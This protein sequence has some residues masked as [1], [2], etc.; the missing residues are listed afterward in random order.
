[1]TCQKNCFTL[2]SKVLYQMTHLGNT[3][4][5]QSIKWLPEHFQQSD[6]TR[7]EMQSGGKVITLIQTL[8]DFWKHRLDKTA[9]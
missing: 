7:A 9:A 4:F 2:R 8:P 1:M 6:L 3:G 5:V